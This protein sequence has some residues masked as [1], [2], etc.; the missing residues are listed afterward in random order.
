VGLN[1]HLLTG[2]D[3]QHSHFMNRCVPPLF[4]FLFG[5]AVLQWLPRKPHWAWLCM[6]ATVVL[7]SLGAY[8]QVRVAGNVVE[9]HD[10]AQNS[11]RLVEVLRGRIDAGS[12]VGST[13]P[14]VLTLL[15]AISTLWT[16]VPLGDRTQASNDEILRRFLLARKLEGATV[17]DVHADFNLTYP[18]K[19]PDRSLSYVLFLGVLDGEQLHA[20][21]DQLWPE[22]DLAEGLSARRLNVLATT[23]T[24]PPLPQSTGWQLVK[25]DPI[26]T[27]NIFQLQPVKP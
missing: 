20:R 9:A 4:F 5:V 17:S 2:Y 18:S 14:Q 6:L 25:A 1:L 19:K 22:L 24:P 8:R 27:W 23:G 12:V 11:V 21:I 7:A 16:F 13:D 3:A 10:R 26:G 15:P